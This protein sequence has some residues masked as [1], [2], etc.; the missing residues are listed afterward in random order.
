MVFNKSN[1]TKRS[2]L[3]HKPNRN[4][5]PSLAPIHSLSKSLDYVK[6]TKPNR[7]VGRL[8]SISKSPAT[9]QFAKLLKMWKK[10]LE[11]EQSV[12]AYLNMEIKSFPLMA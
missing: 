1:K 8:Q 3:L 10:A 6:K 11:G 2:S 7:L 12:G 5:K 4:E 9:C